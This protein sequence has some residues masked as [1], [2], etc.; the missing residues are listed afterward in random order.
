MIVRV[1]TRTLNLPCVYITASSVEDRYFGESNKNI[2]ALFS[3]AQK[4]N[5]IVFIDELDGIASTRSQLDQSYV[6]SM[7]TQLLS[8]MDG[9]VK[10]NSKSIIMGAT[11]MLCHVDPAVRRRMRLHL[12]LKNPD[13]D[14]RRNMITKHL[15][16][17]EDNFVNMTRGMSFSDLEQTCTTAKVLDGDLQQSIL[18]LGNQQS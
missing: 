1:L 15:G 2:K 18:L 14:M 6:N 10:R 8:A 13:D 12:E 11:N 16:V 3:I 5:C 17:C 7:K 4:I 9:F